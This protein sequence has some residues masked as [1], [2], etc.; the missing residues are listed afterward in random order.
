MKI[1]LL[2]HAQHGKDTTAEYMRDIFSL[3]FTSSSL[4]MCERIVFPVLAPL[5]GYKTVQECYEDRKAEEKRKQWYD[6][7]RAYNAKDRSRLAKELTAEMDMY[8]GMRDND[9]LQACKKEK[10]FDVI[11]GVYNPDKPLEPK[12]SMTIDIFRESEILLLNNSTKEALANRVFRARS[13]FGGEI[14]HYS[15]TDE[16]GHTSHKSGYESWMTSAPTMHIP[17]PRWTA[18]GYG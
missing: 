6:L 17:K 9:E 2:G 14:K 4:F 18:E 1:L 13:Y 7:I 5:Y 3:S 12:T 16:S 8:V 10:V 15:H 11:V